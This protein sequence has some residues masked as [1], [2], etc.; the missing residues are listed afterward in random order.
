M[1]IVGLG[2]EARMG[3]GATAGLLAIAAVGDGT[4]SGLDGLASLRKSN[5]ELGIDLRP[6]EQMSVGAIIKVCFPYLWWPM[7]GQELLCREEQMRR[8]ERHYYV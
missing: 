2:F 4:S 7:V 5:R 1:R 3:P 8:Y 6:E